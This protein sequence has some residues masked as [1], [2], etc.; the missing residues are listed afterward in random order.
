MTLPISITVYT[1]LSHFTRTI[2]SLSK[3]NLAHDSILYIFSDAPKEGDEDKVSAVRRFIATIK[4]FR[5]IVP[6]YQPV[7]NIRRNQRQSSSIPIWRHGAVIRME[8]D[9]V[10]AKGFLNFLN[11]GFYWLGANKKICSITGYSPPLD[12][13]YEHKNDCFLLPRASSWGFVQTMRMMQVAHQRLQ[14]SDYGALRKSGKHRLAGDDMP[15]LFLADINSSLDAGDVRQTAYLLQNDLL[16][17]YPRTSL[18]ENIG[19]DGS[20]VNCKR[21]MV[22]SICLWDKRENFDFCTNSKLNRDA[23]YLNNLLRRRAALSKLRDYVEY[24]A[25]C[26]REFAG[27]H[28]FLFI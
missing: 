16:M 22:E 15:R 6:V 2:E 5:E 7:N 20:G 10:T 11:E 19:L 13:A 8:D 18:V 24:Q 9:L 27:N 3:N 1:R 12:W 26:L 17:V 4:G 25:S 14:L 21:S 23:Y 28:D